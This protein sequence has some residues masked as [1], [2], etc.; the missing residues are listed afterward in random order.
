MEKEEWRMIPGYEGLYMVSD[1]GNVYS[2]VKKRLRKI[3]VNP[4][5]YCT[6]TLSNNKKKK[7]KGIHYWVALAF[8]PNPENKPEVH[9]IDYNKTNNSVENL[10]WV[11]TQ[12]HADMHPE[13]YRIISKNVKN[14]KRSKPIAQYTLDL[15]CELIKVWPSIN[16][17]YRQL[18]FANRSI[19]G[20]C[21]GE[22][23]QAY[24]YQWSYFES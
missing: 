3:D 14:G 10:M 21:K 15:P 2:I 9:H 6:I 5:G 4:K 12:E 20:C 7:H 17:I 18:G 13:R 23:K 19:I 8:I 24:G 16:E 1:K 11:T 22:F